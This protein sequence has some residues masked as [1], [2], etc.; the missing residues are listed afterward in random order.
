MSGDQDFIPRSARIEFEFY[1]SKPVESSNEFTAVKEETDVLISTFRQNLKSQIMKV[2]Q[3]EI[4]LLQAAA[5]V[6]FVN[7]VHMV[8]ICTKCNFTFHNERVLIL[9]ACT[10][11]NLIKQASLKRISKP[12]L[13]KPNI[14]KVCIPV[15]NQRKD[16]KSTN[17][18]P[19]KCRDTNMSDV[20]HMRV[21]VRKKRETAEELLEHEDGKQT[22]VI[23][24][25]S[26][27]GN[28]K[29]R[30]YLKQSLRSSLIPEAPREEIEKFASIQNVYGDGNCGMYSIMEGLYHNG[31]EYSEDIDIFRKSIVDYIDSNR[32]KILIGLKFRNK[33]M[34]DGTI[35]G[36]SRNEFID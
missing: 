24:E 2:M 32:N 22:I 8:T 11:K 30:Y 15:L 28:T 21:N 10:K 36:R 29:S 3:M 19:K 35:R 6:Q 31:I 12:K 16:R 5:N 13:P 34:S 7:S 14:K 26:N 1:V 20:S 17:I 4:A 23:K 33:R 27:I 25:E 9:P 18:S